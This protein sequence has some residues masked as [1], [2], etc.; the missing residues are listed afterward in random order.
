M[1]F[2]AVRRVGTLGVSMEILAPARVVDVGI[3]SMACVCGYTQTVGSVSPNGRGIR[4][5]G[6]VENGY[7]RRAR[8]SCSGQHAN[9]LSRLFVVRN[10]DPARPPPRMRKIARLDR[11]LFMRQRLFLALSGHPNNANPL[12]FDKRRHN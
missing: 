2:S 8:G 4:S 6:H 7:R 1:V 12:A 9:T 11:L 5:I 3:F 10:D